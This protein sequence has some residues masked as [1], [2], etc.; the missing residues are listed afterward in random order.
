MNYEA[1]IP[2]KIKYY[3][4]ICSELDG[5]LS[6]S[7]ISWGNKR[8]TFESFGYIDGSGKLRKPI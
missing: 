2:Y 8:N 4:L 3:S 6:T 5:R 7:K 1:N